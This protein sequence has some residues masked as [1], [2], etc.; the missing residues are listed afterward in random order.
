[1]ISDWVQN[2]SDQSMSVSI[3]DM[4]VLAPEILARLQRSLYPVQTGI[5][6]YHDYTT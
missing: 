4:K 1:M 3:P 5:I 6:L 2:L